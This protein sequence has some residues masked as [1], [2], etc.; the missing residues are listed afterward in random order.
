MHGTDWNEDLMRLP[1]DQFNYQGRLMVHSA[2]QLNSHSTKRAEQCGSNDDTRAAA[3]HVL[4][5]DAQLDERRRRAVR[6]PCS[7]AIR[8]AWT[9]NFDKYAMGECVDISRTGLR[10]L[11]SDPIPVRTSVCFKADCLAFGGSGTVR[12]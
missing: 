1:A 8:L 4:E 11:I 2:S 12:H 7:G 5:A 9:S 10:M 3:I 6:Y